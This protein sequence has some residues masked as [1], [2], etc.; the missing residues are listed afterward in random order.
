MYFANLHIR[1]KNS[2]FVADFVLRVIRTVTLRG[3]EP[4]SNAKTQ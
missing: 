4:I 3:Q 2:N 1:K